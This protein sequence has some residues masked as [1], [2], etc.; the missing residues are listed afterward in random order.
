ME[1]TARE[2]QTIKNA[3]ETAEADYRDY[4]AQNAGQRIGEQFKRQADE[5]RQIV[6]RIEAEG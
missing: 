3:L 1:F 6:N 2:L 5:C 4:A